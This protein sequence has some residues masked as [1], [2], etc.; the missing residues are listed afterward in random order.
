LKNEWKIVAAFLAFIVIVAYGVNANRLIQVTQ[1][2]V[3][4]VKY[5]YVHIWTFTCYTADEAY[6]EYWF[7]YTEEEEAKAKQS[8]INE[9]FT[10]KAKIAII[11][12]ITNE[13]I[14]NLT[15]RGY[16]VYIRTIDPNVVLDQKKEIRYYCD[17]AQFMG[18]WNVTFRSR[19]YITCTVIFETDKPIAES[20]IPVWLIY[21]LAVLIEKLP[22]IIMAVYVGTAVY[23]LLTTWLP[24]MTTRESKIVTE[25]YDSD[26]GQLVKREEKYVKEPDWFSTT[27]FWI[28]IGVVAAIILYPISGVITAALLSKRRKKK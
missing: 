6:E 25:Y 10:Q 11:T 5:P 7:Y 4:W 21:L 16:D 26:T 3:G 24:S 1:G 8:E 14:E 27:I 12:E 15:A 23:Q 13:L 18:Y 9:E 2:N 22:W 20:P 19:L 28:I 17:P